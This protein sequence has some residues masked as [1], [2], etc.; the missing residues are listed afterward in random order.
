MI[1]EVVDLHDPVGRQR[2]PRSEPPLESQVN[3]VDASPAKLLRG[4][5][6][7]RPQA[8]AGIAPMSRCPAVAR[9]TLPGP[10]EVQAAQLKTV[11]N[12]PDAV[13]HEP[14]AL[15]GDR[16]A[17]V[18]PE[19]R[20]TGKVTCVRPLSGGPSRLQ[21]RK[22]VRADPCQRLRNRLVNAVCRPW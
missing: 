15:V 20:A 4:T 10:E 1:E 6:T 16:Q 22:R 8:V 9:R 18:V 7:I 12:V 13:E 2:L 3:A 11:A 17:V 19:V 5:M 14:V 21:R